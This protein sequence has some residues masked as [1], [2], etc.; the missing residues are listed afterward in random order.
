[1][2]S[3]DLLLVAACGL[4]VGTAAA[5]LVWLNQ[6]LANSYF[7]YGL[8]RLGYLTLIETMT[9]AML[10]CAALAVALYAASLI[11]M[12]MPGWTRNGASQFAILAGVLPVMLYIID[13]ILSSR[14]GYTL[15][16]AA[17]KIWSK[18]TGFAS[19]ELTAG[20]LKQSFLSNLKGAILLG[21]SLIAVAVILWLMRRIPWAKLVDRVAARANVPGRAALI[22][23]ALAIILNAVKFLDASLFAPEGPNIIFIAVDCLRP[24]HIGYYGYHR[25]TTPE[26]DARLNSAV[27]FTNAYSNAPWTKPSI[28]TLFTSLYPNVHTAVGDREILPDKALTLAEV[29]KNDGYRTVYMNAANPFITRRFGFHQGFDT[30]EDFPAPYDASELT[31]RFLSILRGR[32]GRKL[33][34]YLHY[35]DV[36]V[37]YWE[38]EFSF[39]FTDT[40]SDEELRPG[41]VVTEAIR[42]RTAEGRMSEADMRHIIGLYDGQIR[43]VDLCISSIFREIEL[44]GMLNETLIVIFADHGE[45][46]WEHGN[47]EHGHT[48]YNELLRIPLVIRGPG[49]PGMKVDRRVSLIDIMPTVLE[50]AG[51]NVVNLSLQGS[52]VISIIGNPR[53]DEEHLP[54]F[55]TGTLYGPERYCLMSGDKKIVV[56]TDDDVGKLELVG[57]AGTSPAELYDL[58][59]DPLEQADRQM[60]DPETLSELGRALVEFR[61]LP[62]LAGRRSTIMDEDL[63]QRLRSVGY[64]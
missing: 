27:V 33:F 15:G 49:L 6:A 34:A 57:Y 10:L 5:F 4:L 58:S 35:M 28:G 2:R 39:E 26:L 44:A 24:D 16:L 29:L 59:I 22:V 13:H 25:P 20:Q 55:A 7:E 60:S 54:V 18:I 46:F 23:L 52:S 8:F 12:R 42:K 30:A 50:L 19:G 3:R 51:V 61:D 53:R 48:V 1:M 47:F 9:P 17:A 64:L 56:N 14:T 41:N 43:Y 45:E 11:L 31:A 32:P 62:R 36:H 38:N 40:T 37:P 21:A 63:K